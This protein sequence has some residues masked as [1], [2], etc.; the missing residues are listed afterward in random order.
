LDLLPVWGTNGIAAKSDNYLDEDEFDSSYE[1]L[2]RLCERIGDAKPK[3]VPEDIIKTLPINTYIAGKSKTVEDR[4][5]ICL[6]DYEINDRL[7]DL[8]CSHD[9]HQDCIDI[10]FKNSDKCPICRHSVIEK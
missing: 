2:L 10:W 3:G 1:G 8:P 9:F 6:T 7:R 5:T 4:C